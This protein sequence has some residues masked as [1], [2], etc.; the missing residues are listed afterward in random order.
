[1][2]RIYHAD[3]MHSSYGSVVCL[4]CD[5]SG[6]RVAGIPS[7]FLRYRPTKSCERHFGTVVERD[8]Y[9]GR[10]DPAFSTRGRK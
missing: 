2:S 7:I 4:F 8:T 5:L 1:M 9:I 3:L 10:Q 6:V